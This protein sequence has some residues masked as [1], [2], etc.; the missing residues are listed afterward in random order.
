MSARR[1]TRMLD[2]KYV[3]YL[4]ITRSAAADVPELR[5]EKCL[6]GCVFVNTVPVTLDDK[7]AI[8]VLPISEHVHLDML[9]AFSET[10]AKLASNKQIEKLFP[11]YAPDAIPP[12]GDLWR[13]PVYASLSL[14]IGEWIAFHCG[15][16]RTVIALAFDDFKRIAEPHIRD[17]SDW[18]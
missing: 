7:P 17:L 11:G 10:D 18:I 2:E 4:V 9:T 15:T 13:L 16:R 8:V 12:F 5:I 1:L 3:P 14:G 6:G